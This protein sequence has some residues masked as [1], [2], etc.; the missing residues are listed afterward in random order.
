MFKWSLWPER[1]ALSPLCQGC[2]WVLTLPLLSPCL[3]PHVSYASLTSS[4]L[5]VKMLC[6]WLV[7]CRACLSGW[8]SRSWELPG[9]LLTPLAGMTGRS[10][11]DRGW[12]LSWAG[13][14]IPDSSP[15]LQV[16]FGPSPSCCASVTPEHQANTQGNDLVSSVLDFLGHTARR[17]K[18]YEHVWDLCKETL[19]PCQNALAIHHVLISH[20]LWPNKGQTLPLRLRVEGGT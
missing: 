8:R 5:T 15:V 1:P 10:Y 11:A 3:T 19:W 2:H 14:K 13:T 7:G 4:R 18:S 6:M 16:G 20:I 17:C 12:G 9:C